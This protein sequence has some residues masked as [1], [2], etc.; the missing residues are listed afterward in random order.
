M[1]KNLYIHVLCV[2]LLKSVRLL[3]KTSVADSVLGSHTLCQHTRLLGLV[4]ILLSCILLL[5]AL[6][7]SYCSYFL[8]YLH[9]SLDYRVGVKLVSSM[10]QVLVQRTL[11]CFLILS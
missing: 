5:L 1:D 4:T 11:L 7:P 2:L 10:K 3:V 8:V 9:S 6:P